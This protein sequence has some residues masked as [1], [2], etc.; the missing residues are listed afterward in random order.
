MTGSP[1]GRRS[2]S[3]S[4]GVGIRA[5]ERA[6]HSLAML[7]S[8]YAHCIEGQEVEANR[9]IEAARWHPPQPKIAVHAV[10]LRPVATITG[11]PYRACTAIT[12]RCRVPGGSQP[13]TSEGSSD[14]PRPDHG[15]AP[16]V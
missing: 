1:A 3:I 9:R 16:Q 12:D 15:A 11:D 13:H 7:L 6:G 5:A 2:C 8:T 14:G 4:S 10:P